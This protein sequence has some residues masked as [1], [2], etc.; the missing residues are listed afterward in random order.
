MIAFSFIRVGGMLNVNDQRVNT[1]SGGVPFSE[2][3]VIVSF[4]GS[5]VMKVGSPPFSP[6][7]VQKNWFPSQSVTG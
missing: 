4:T 1:P 6:G 7:A 3:I 5:N 2:A